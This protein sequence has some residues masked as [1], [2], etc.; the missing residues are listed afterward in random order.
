MGKG[1]G[2]PFRAQRAH[3]FLGQ[4]SLCGAWTFWGR[5]YDTHRKWMSVPCKKCQALKDDAYGR[6]NIR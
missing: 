4:K 3:Y 2:V 1:W 6:T 5:T